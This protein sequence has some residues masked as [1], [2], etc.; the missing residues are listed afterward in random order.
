MLGKYKPLKTATDMCRFVDILENKRFYLPRIPSLNDPLEGRGMHIAISGYAGISIALNADQLPSPIAS[1]IEHSRALCLTSDC[2]NPQMWV[3]YADG[4]RGACVCVSQGGVFS[5]AEKVKYRGDV[6]LS[7]ISEPANSQE[8]IYDAV[9][10]ALLIKQDGW[11]YENE[12]RIIRQ[13]SENDAE[14]HL[15]FGRRDLVAVVIGH[16]AADEVHKFVEE[17]CKRLGIPLYKTIVRNLSAQVEIV[18]DE[19][20]VA[21]DGRLLDDQLASYYAAHAE[22]QLCAQAR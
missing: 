22:L 4:F 3:H 11:S 1:A 16:C 5:E 13:P 19:F 18:P 8:E 20:R 21:Y 9:H 2:R 12:Y 14:A 10:Q 15:N 7:M 17:T 6:D